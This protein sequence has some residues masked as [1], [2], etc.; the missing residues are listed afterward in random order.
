MLFKLQGSHLSFTMEIH[1]KGQPRN[2]VLPFVNCGA[3]P[4]IFDREDS[5]NQEEVKQLKALAQKFRREIVEMVYTAQ[6]GHP[7]GS[8]SII[9]VL[10]Y[11]FFHEME[12]P[13]QNRDVLS[14][15]RLVLSKGHATPALYSC[16][17]EKGFFPEAELKRFRQIDSILQGHP[18]NEFVPGVDVTTGSLGQGFPQAVGMALGMRL[19]G[20]KRHVFAILGDGE[21]QE[22]LI[23]EAAMSA[24]HYKTANLTVF[25][26]LNGLQI[27]GNVKDVMNVNP[28]ADKFAASHWHV[29]EI[30]GHDFNE[31]DKAVQAAHM[32]TD[33]PS[34][35]IAHT[36][37]GKGVS[38][39][40]NN[41]KFHGSPP[42]DEEYKIAMEELAP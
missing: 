21:C 23:W 20:S 39:M 8:L 2:N 6:S 27:D 42:N 32:V 35:I 7:G 3:K 12:Y 15:D 25:V 36:I 5:L 40:E 28:V 10:T 22:G 38:F 18:E 17:A 26:D 11:L 41:Y 33:K 34:V 9:D 31:I 24:G 19:A 29:Q 14:T 13:V 4:S 37:K 30:N 16:L 1:R